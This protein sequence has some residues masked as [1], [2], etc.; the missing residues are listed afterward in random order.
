MT[1]AIRTE[2]L[3]SQFEGLNAQLLR[4]L[5]VEHLTQQKQGLC[6]EASAMMRSM[7]GAA[8]RRG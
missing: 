5:L 1:D 7:F 4:R 2:N 8:L 3:L 6:W